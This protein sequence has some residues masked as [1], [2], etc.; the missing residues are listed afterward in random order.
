MYR[1]IIILFL[2]V[3]HVC[4]AEYNRYNPSKNGQIDQK[5]Y[6]YDLAICAIF[7]DEAPYLKEWIEFHRLVGVE[8]FYL[9]NH[10]SRDHYQEVLKPYIL[11]GLV[12]L[13]DKTKVANRIKMKALWLMS[14]NNMTHLEVCTQIGGYLALLTS[15]KF[16]K[17]N[18]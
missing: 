11:S 16:P 7:Q 15:T 18:C 3:T 9:Y 10:R 6:K 17:I 2:C 4:H 5:E 12:E 1:L 14:L 8:H 13:I